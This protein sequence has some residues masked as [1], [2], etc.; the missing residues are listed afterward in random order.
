M[1]HRPREKTKTSFRAW[2]ASRRPPVDE[3]WAEHGAVQ[4]ESG[5][6]LDG[7]RVCEQVVA[8]AGMWAEPGL[9]GGGEPVAFPQSGNQR[10]ER[11]V[12]DEGGLPRIGNRPWAHFPQSG[13][14]WGGGELLLAGY[15]SG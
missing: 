4:V 7:R 5:A 13:N 2:P 9:G 12:A 10:G 15:F 3:G 11:G 8:D 14:G 1:Q 6:D